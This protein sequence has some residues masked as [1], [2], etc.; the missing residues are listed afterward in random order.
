[1]NTIRNCRVLLNYIP[2]LRNEH[3]WLEYV[4]SGLI[5]GAMTG[6][7]FSDREG[8]GFQVT[9]HNSRFS[10]KQLCLIRGT[11]YGLILSLL[12]GANANISNI[13][14]QIAELRKWEKYWK[15]RREVNFDFD[16]KNIH[17][18][19]HSWATDLIFFISIL[20]RVKKTEPT[21]LPETELN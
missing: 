15:Q 2:V 11:G 6:H 14:L 16:W 5:T 13:Q 8:L 3:G 12:M 9:K 1:M 17:F 21:K 7:L 19:Q 20:F 4:S 18:T 10:Y